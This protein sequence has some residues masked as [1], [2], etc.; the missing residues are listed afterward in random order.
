[1]QKRREFLKQTGLFASGLYLAPF[2]TNATKKSN[3][4]ILLVSGWQDVNIG[5]IV[6]K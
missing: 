6:L 1:M 2:I 3:P 5:D 4:T